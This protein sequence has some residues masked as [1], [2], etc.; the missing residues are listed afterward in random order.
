MPPELSGLV[1]QLSEI[2]G[3]QGALAT[4]PV[5]LNAVETEGL[6]RCAEILRA[7]V[8]SLKK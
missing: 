6:R 2:V 3:G 1:R 7:A 5:P 8:D 4:I